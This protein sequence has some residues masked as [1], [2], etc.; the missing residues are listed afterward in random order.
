VW[1]TSCCPFYH[2][3]RFWEWASLTADTT[4]C[5]C[6]SLY[7]QWTLVEQFQLPTTEGVLSFYESS[8]VPT[9]SCLIFR[10]IARTVYTSQELSFGAT[11]HGTDNLA[12]Q[13]S[14]SNPKLPKSTIRLPLTKW[15]GAHPSWF[16]FTKMLCRRQV[17]KIKIASQVSLICL[18]YSHVLSHLL[19]RQ[20]QQFI[21][22]MGGCN[23]EERTVSK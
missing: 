11:S 1:I 22:L 17:T 2:P 5:T 9:C 19:A 4:T 16:N 6:Q 20:L 10:G 15:V 7:P 13:N 21:Y 14:K 3:C 18:D 8:Q 23:Y 12:S